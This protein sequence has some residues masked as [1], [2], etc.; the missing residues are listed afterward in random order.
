MVSKTRIPRRAVR[1]E[2][3]RSI[4]REAEARFRHELVGAG[5]RMLL[6]ARVIKLRRALGLQ[7]KTRS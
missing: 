1:D 4:L 7:A 2:S 3:R 5:E 6:W